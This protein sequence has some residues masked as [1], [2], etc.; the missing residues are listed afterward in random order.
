[1]KQQCT[2]HEKVRTMK[3]VRSLHYCA[4]YRG[5]ESGGGGGEKGLGRLFKNDRIRRNIT[6]EI[7]RPSSERV[8]EE[9]DLCFCFLYMRQ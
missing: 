5:R 3:T 7:Q 9:A 1:M 2:Y 6:T 4:I 8:E